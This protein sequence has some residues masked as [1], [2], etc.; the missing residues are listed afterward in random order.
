MV[1]L[2]RPL[3][4][5]PLFG[6]EDAAVRDVGH[7]LYASLLGLGADGRPA[8]DLAAAWSVSADGHTYAFTI[9][10]GRRWSDGSALTARDVAATVSLVQ[11]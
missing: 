5:D 8:S 6:R 2:H 10:P 9:P 1:A 3:N 7:L 11:S 4:L